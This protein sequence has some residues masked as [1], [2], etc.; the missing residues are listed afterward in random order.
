M[1]ALIN[2]SLLLVFIYIY[3]IDIGISHY[4]SPSNST[5]SGTC[6]FVKFLWFHYMLVRYKSNCFSSCSYLCFERN[7]FHSKKN[8]A[9]RLHDI[10]EVSKVGC[11]PVLISASYIF[12]ILFRA[13]FDF[14]C[15]W[16][17]SAFLSSQNRSHF[18]LEVECPSKSPLNQTK[19]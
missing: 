19:R 2:S 7:Q 12:H 15:T 16:S 4:P 9:L 14:L 11:L 6:I 10:L 8:F 3:S 18:S 1:R 17:F 5:S 13:V